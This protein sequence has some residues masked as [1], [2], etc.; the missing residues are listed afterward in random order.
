MN[1]ITI[2]SENGNFRDYNIINETFYI[3]IIRVRMAQI[4]LRLYNIYV[5]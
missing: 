3:Y 2:Y 5:Y 1:E 4:Y